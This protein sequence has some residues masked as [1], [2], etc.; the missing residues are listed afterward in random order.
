MRLTPA[1]GDRLQLYL[2]ALL[3]RERR[4]RGLRLNVPEA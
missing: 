2:A 1:E 3:A 4:V